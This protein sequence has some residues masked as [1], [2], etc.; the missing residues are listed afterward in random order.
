MLRNGGGIGRTLSGSCWTSDSLLGGMPRKAVQPAPRQG[1][2]DRLMSSKSAVRARLGNDEKV[3]V[4]YIEACGAAASAKT[5]TLHAALT[6]P[7][8]S[9]R[10]PALS[11]SRS[12]QLKFTR[13]HT[14]GN[15]SPSSNKN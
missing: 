8:P 9:V 1:S 5:L 13:K 3:D 2:L 10:P 14:S 7:A 12:S 11:S 15:D 4:D 6:W